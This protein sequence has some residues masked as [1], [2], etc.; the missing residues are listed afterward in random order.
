M[1][2][3]D[4]NDGAIDGAFYDVL[5]FVPE[6]KFSKTLCGKRVAQSKIEYGS[7]VTCPDCIAIRRS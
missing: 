6:Q 7:G 3:A 4:W 1:K 5:G 2:H